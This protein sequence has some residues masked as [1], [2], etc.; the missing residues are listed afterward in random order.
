MLDIFSTW[1]GKRRRHKTVHIIT[2][3][4]LTRRVSSSF[5]FTR[6][7]TPMGTTNLHAIITWCIHHKR[8]VDIFHA[9]PARYICL[10]YYIKAFKEVTQ[11][12]SFWRQREIMMRE[13][14]TVTSDRLV[15][16]VSTSRNKYSI[17]AVIFRLTDRKT[18]R[19][20]SDV[21]T[22]RQTSLAS[23]KL[24]AWICHV[25]EYGDIYDVPIVYPVGKKIGFSTIALV[26]LFLYGESWFC[27]NDRK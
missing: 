24:R 23:W 9:V 4:F 5:I 20:W 1:S 11:S 19:A 7:W 10:Q 21:D 2:Q 16:L 12:V 6:H 17:A 25:V 27:Q 14:S 13:W 18:V 26:N 22:N 3:T 15:S 8:R